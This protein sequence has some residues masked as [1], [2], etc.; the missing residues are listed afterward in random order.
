MLLITR[1]VPQNLKFYVDDVEGEWAY[2]PDE[3]FDLIHGR[4][5]GGAIKDWNKLLRQC[6]DNLKPGAYLELHDYES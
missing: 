2:N 3:A 6:Y 4:G 1:R 5:M